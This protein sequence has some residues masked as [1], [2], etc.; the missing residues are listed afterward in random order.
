MS[1]LDEVS[2]QFSRIILILNQSPIRVVLA[3]YS[4]TGGKNGKHSSV[5]IVEHLH[6]ILHGG[7]S[8]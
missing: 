4:K 2:S 3:Q 6:D 5:S 8:F 1:W 7:S